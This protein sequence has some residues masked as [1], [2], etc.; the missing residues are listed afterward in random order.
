MPLPVQNGV[1]QTSVRCKQYYSKLHL[2][3]YFTSR[4]FCNGFD[5]TFTKLAQ[6]SCTG[7]FLI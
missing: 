5:I 2:L 6:H 7:Q 3:Y 4:Y 1:K